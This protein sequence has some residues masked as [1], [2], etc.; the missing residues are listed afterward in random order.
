MAKHAA[1]VSRYGE[2]EQADR[3][4]L[5]FIGEN[6]GAMAEDIRDFYRDHLADAARIVSATTMLD[7]YELLPGD[8]IGINFFTRPGTGGGNFPYTFPFAF[9]VAG[10]QFD[11]LT[12]TQKF[13]LEDV[14]V[15]PGNYRDKRITRTA[16]VAREVP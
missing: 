4:L 1:S 12:G 14:R 15:M 6:N 16:V 7:Q 9:P 11:G 3:F 8:V 2:R 13:L 5:D 10:E